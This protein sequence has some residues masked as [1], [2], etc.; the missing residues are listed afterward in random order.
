MVGLCALMSVGAHA[1]SKVTLSYADNTLKGT[2]KWVVKLGGSATTSSQR[3]K[4]PAG[5]TSTVTLTYSG[6]D[7]L[8]T[9]VVFSWKKSPA[10]GTFSANYGSYTYPAT[11]TA[12][13]AGMKSI[14]FTGNGKSEAQINQMTVYYKTVASS[15]GSS[16]GS[17]TSGGNTSGS[18]TSTVQGTSAYDRNAPVGW[19]T[20]GGKATGGNNQGKVTVT[21]KADLLR[22]L[23]GTTPKTI[24]VKGTISFTGME[25][26]KDAANKTVLG[27]PGSALV[28]SIHNAVVSQS[29]ILSFSRC[30]NIVLRNLTFKSAGA[31]DIDG[32]DNLQFQT[33]D[34]VWVDH[35][36]FQDGVDGNFDANN[37]SDHIAVTWCRFRY[38]I[39]PY[40]GGSG[41]SA[42]HRNCCLWGGSDSNTKDRGH[43]R[44]T[45]ANC[46]WDQGCHERMPRVRFGQVHIVNC[47]FSCT[48]SNYCIGAAYASNIYAEK[49]AFVGVSTPWKCYATKSGKTDYNI[50]MTGNIG[51]PDEQKRSGSIAYFNPYS[52]YSYSAMPAASVQRE[53]SG[54][55]GAT[56]KIS[57]GAS[58]AKAFTLDDQTTAIQT[59]EAEGAQTVVATQIFTAAG[60]EIPS[61]QPGLNIIRTRYADGRVT[62]RK[63]M[64]R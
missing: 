64:Q 36:D 4:L 2:G 51:A 33:C 41:G 17:S 24:Y 26:V 39:K 42:D 58:L 3:I 56:L 63:V 7:K 34:Y 10:D 62:V 55:A 37:G 30:K 15:G 43:L 8:I 16:T 52:V 14:R 23:E 6:K 1:D 32:N 22:E 35:C 21:T 49:N 13:S 47:L 27:L 31:Y 40:A 50:T 28:N 11:W 60:K 57:E 19:A 53:V 46:W 18:S 25:T 12:P 38:L 9:K 61:L 5:S 20:V 59:V 45:F 54:H 29:G 44:T 48:G